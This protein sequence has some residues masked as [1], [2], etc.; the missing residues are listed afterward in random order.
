M[1]RVAKLFMYV[2]TDYKEKAADWNSVDSWASFYV[3]WCSDKG[4][5][6]LDDDRKVYPKD[7]MTVEQAITILSRLYDLATYWES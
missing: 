7:C 5:M 1:T 2:G 4:L 6:R 3:R